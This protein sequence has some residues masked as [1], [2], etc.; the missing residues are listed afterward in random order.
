MV[1]PVEG[2]VPIVETD[3]SKCESRRRKVGFRC[4]RL[5][6][7]EHLAIQAARDLLTAGAAMLT[8]GALFLPVPF[9]ARLALAFGARASSGRYD[10]ASDL[11]GDGIIDGEDLAVLGSAFGRGQ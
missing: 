5:G 4:D 1:A 3:V 8:I 9:A 7:L 10:S 11:N 2:F 6:R